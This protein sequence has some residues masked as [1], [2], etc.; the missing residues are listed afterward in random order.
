MFTFN[1]FFINQLFPFGFNFPRFYNNRS[2]RRLNTLMGIPVL[3]TNGEQK[4]LSVAE[5]KTIMTD[6]NIGLT[7]ATD[8]TQI[9][10]MVRK[11]YNDCKIKK[12]SVVKY[13]EEM[14]RCEDI[15]KLLNS[16]SD[17]TTNVTNDFK[18]FNEL[19]AEVKEIKELLRNIKAVSPEDKESVNTD[20]KETK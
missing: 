3:R 6:S 7:I 4:K 11:S 8:K 18:E 13:D 16:N 2:R 14:R 19:K 10:D 1:P 5:D 15:L 9:I 20:D 17:I 12:E